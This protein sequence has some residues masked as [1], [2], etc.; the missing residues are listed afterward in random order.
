MVP[1]RPRPPS[2]PARRTVRSG[3]GASCYDC[4]VPT[5]RL[6]VFARALTAVVGASTVTAAAL[7][8]SA[9][10]V[11]SARPGPAAA[12][13]FGLPAAAGP[14]GGP[15]APAGGLVAPGPGTVGPDSPSPAAPPVGGGAVTSQVVSGP[16]A[17]WLVAADGGIF[18]FGGVPFKGSAGAVRL[19][20]PIV[21]MAPTPSGAGYWLVGRDGTVFAYG[22][23]PPAGSPATLPLGVRPDAPVVAL[24]PTPSGKGYWV[25]TAHGD[26]YTFGDAPFLGSLGRVHLAA[27]VV[28]MAATPDG[29]GYWMVAADGGIFTFGDAAFS[30]SAGAIHLVSPAVGMAATPD[31][32]GYWLVAADGGIFTYGDASFRGST[33]ARKLNQPIVGMAAGHTLDPYPPATSGYDISWPQCGGVLPP[34]PG[35]IAVVGANNGRAYTF[36]PC[37]PAEG[38][39][40]AGA[41]SLYINLNAPPDGSTQGLTGPAGACATTDAGCIAYNYG[42][43]HAAASWGF[44]TASGV[45]AGVWWLDVETANSWD[46]DP[47]V[48]AQVIRGAI[49]ELTNQGVVVGI[50]STSH[51]WTI[52]AGS[53]A[54]GLPIWKAT[55]ADLA[56]AVDAC[57]GSTADHPN[58]AGGVPW[59][60]Q[61]GGSG[62][63]QDYACPVV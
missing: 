3:R 7:A 51:Q 56:A 38:S 5:S 14:A 50:Y 11:T 17:Y 21:G 10:A 4:R 8:T 19:S 57:S 18:T 23:A 39:W 54:P 31:G 20:A 47:T 1:S 45:A 63:D 35:A 44:A 2:V 24:A 34:A 33:G 28:G 59:L 41:A 9:G 13:A 32:G 6:S 53:Y 30:G 61:Y 58:F 27:P 15:G 48:N 60:A 22:D 36:N 12:S 49:D 42:Y 26:L 52:I 40:A 29:N 55:G 43:N 46:A 16:G 25:V 37:L 62:F